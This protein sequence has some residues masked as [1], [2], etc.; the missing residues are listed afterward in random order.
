MQSNA[1]GSSRHNMMI[2]TLPSMGPSNFAFGKNLAQKSGEGKT[3][4]LMASK[5]DEV[6]TL[7]QPNR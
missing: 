3:L 6:N 4:E 1:S 7:H 2:K 5:D